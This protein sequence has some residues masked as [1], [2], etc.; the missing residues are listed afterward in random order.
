MD[1]T[2]K[3]TDINMADQK[4][5]KIERAVSMNVDKIPLT[6]RT[7]YKTASAS[8]RTR[9]KTLR[10]D[11]GFRDSVI[12]RKDDTIHDYHCVKHGR[13]PPVD[14]I[15]FFESLEDISTV[16]EVTMQICADYIR[17]NIIDQMRFVSDHE[18]L[19]S[20]I[21]RGELTDAN[22]EE[23]L[24]G[25]T[26][27]EKNLC[28]LWAAFLKREDLLEGLLRCGADVNYTE[29][30]EGF[31]ALHLGAFV[32][33]INTCQ[34]LISNG[35][36]V[37]LAPKSY[38]PLHSAAFGNSH[39]VLKL[40]LDN[41]AKVDNIPG[42]GL[43]GNLY[44]SPLHS[45]VKANAI[46]CVEL[47]VTE[48][49]G[50]NALGPGGYTPLHIAADLGH[51]G[52][53]KIL[54]EIAHANPN[55]KTAEKRASALHLA[56]EGGFHECVCMLLEHGAEADVRNI[57]GQTPLHLAAKAQSV[58][59][60]E[61]LLKVGGCD[62]NT[63]DVD[64]RSPLHAAVCRTLL[65]F[66][67]VEVLISWRADVN[68]QD[69]YGYT[70]LHVAALN[71]L[72]QC[73]ETLIYHGAD[74]TARSKNG[75]T[76]LSIITRKT[77]GSISMLYQKLDSSISLHDPEATNREVELKLDFRVLLQHSRR[78][79]ISFLKTLVDEGQKE[80]LQ[81]PLCEAFLHLKWQKIRKYYVSRLLFNFIFVVALT[82][83][84]WMALAHNCFNETKRDLNATQESNDLC[85]NNSV[86]SKLI[87]KHPFIV[88]IEWFVLVFITVC[89]T[90]RKVYGIAGY[91]YSSVWHYL[92]QLDNIVEWLVIICV[93][94]ISFIYTGRTYSWQNH[95]GALAVLCAWTN[96]MVM[97]G[98]LPM[99][100]SYVAM[101]TR[102]QKEFLKL[103]TAYVCLLIGF[104]ITFCVIFP[105][106]S[107]FANPFIGLIKVLVMMTG[108][109]DLDLVLEGSGKKPAF[110]LEISAQVTFILFLLFV[111]VILMNLLVGIAVH[112]IQGLQKTAGLLKL[113]R[114]TNLIAY[115]ELALF[116]GYLP[117]YCLGL[118]QSTAL[119]SPSAY[120]VVLHVKPLNPQEKR[121]PFDV[122]QN[123][124]DVAKRRKHNGHTIS[125]RGS[126]NTT[127]SACTRFRTSV[128][129]P[130]IQALYANL[131][132]NSRT[133]NHLMGDIVEIKKLMKLNEIL[134]QDILDSLNKKT[135]SC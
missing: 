21:E 75:T 135:S 10:M 126:T 104:T 70:P 134:M 114:Q 124:Y 59:C 31:S 67:V 26:V 8:L 42:K 127:S 41:G 74:I 66:E 99:L 88:E 27:T 50:I 108:E 18:E 78:G 64:K 6:V 38:S 30:V 76:A 15:V 115:T 116:C 93:F 58:D 112:D 11:Q 46:D 3:I 9:W 133:I 84:V 14:D 47:L 118:L 61:T 102:V 54:L 101:Y 103:L 29:P 69:K 44:G 86:V 91:R 2:P 128:Y 65:A 60:V 53:M 132:E 24:R 73:V 34:F 36:S 39:R 33:C 23:V 89:E 131:D 52:C 51:A 72:A 83:Y 63:L 109:L 117:R 12:S 43:G 125:S 17:Q 81:H 37:N 4:K 96:L 5:A 122:L 123:A 22:V 97:I 107:A 113:V 80:V 98:Q 92:S 1:L 129:D 32:G 71:E 48:G 7:K 56:A 35:A 95:I 94:V 100:G 45:A 120:R 85:Q 105:T 90:V 111:T 77:P 106:S 79:E 25:C 119:V 110:L 19:L 49:G 82:L 68:A 121:L 28:L 20:R 87:Q 55:V 57:R 13:S 62:V 16:P 130:N 40:L